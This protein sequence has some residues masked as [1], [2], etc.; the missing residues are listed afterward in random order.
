MNYVLVPAEIRQ[1]FYTKGPA[2]VV[3]TIGSLEPFQCGLM[4]MRT[5]EGFLIVNNERQKKLNTVVSEAIT[6]R[7]RRVSPPFGSIASFA[8]SLSPTLMDVVRSQAYQLF[9]DSSSAKGDKPRKASD[10]SEAKD[11]NEASVV[12]RAFAQVTRGV[13]W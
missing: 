4:A 3:A 5:G 10:G 11:E 13:H 12:G 1:Q 9:P 7:P 2:R 8:D 6:F